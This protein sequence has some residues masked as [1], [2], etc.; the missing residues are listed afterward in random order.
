MAY[1]LETSEGFPIDIEVIDVIEGYVLFRGGLKLDIDTY[2]SLDEEIDD[3]EDADQCIVEHPEYGF[4][5][6]DIFP[7]AVTKQ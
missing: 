3:G 1:P 2:L 4:L 7:E 5:F 6:I